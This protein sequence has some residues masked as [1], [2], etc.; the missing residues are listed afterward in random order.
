MGGKQGKGSRGHELP[1]GGAWCSP[2]GMAVVKVLGALFKVPLT[3]VVGEY[4]IGHVQHGLPFLWR[5]CSA[6][7][8]RDSPLPW[9]AWCPRT[10][11]L[12]RWNDARQV[13]RVALPLFLAFGTW[14][15]PG[16]AH[17]LCRPLL[18]GGGRSGL[19]PGA[20][21]GPRPGGGLW[22]AL[23]Q[24][25]VAITRGWGIWFPQPFPRCWRPLLKLGTGAW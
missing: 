18:S 1:A 11:S 25:T 3:Y 22:P 23:P 15:R 20:H 19:C 2:A 21:A 6:W 4:G 8:P 13:K 14:G 7:P 10:A 12:G 24:C 17:L 16:D 5:R 9:P